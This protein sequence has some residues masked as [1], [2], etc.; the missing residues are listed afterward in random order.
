[1]IAALLPAGA[2]AKS[3]LLR[4]GDMIHAVDGDR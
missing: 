3:R 1:V 4:T 2:A